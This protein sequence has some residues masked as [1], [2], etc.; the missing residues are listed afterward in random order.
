MHATERERPAQPVAGDGDEPRRWLHDRALRSSIR[1]ADLWRGCL[2][3]AAL[4]A[5]VGAGECHGGDKVLYA[6]EPITWLCLRDVPPG[7]FPGTRLTS[8]REVRCV[9]PAVAT[10]RHNMPR[11]DFASGARQAWDFRFPP[12]RST[13]ARRPGGG[14]LDGG[15]HPREFAVL[16]RVSGRMTWPRSSAWTEKGARSKTF[17]A[18]LRKICRSICDAAAAANPA[19]TRSR[20]RQ[21]QP[22]VP[23]R[24]VRQ[25]PSRSAHERDLNPP[26]RP[27]L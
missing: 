22:A 20:R 17:P 8:R 23:L 14:I 27:S 25:H 15:R 9:T 10:L 7:H 16:N 2:G 13:R 3:P 21:P 1:L 26:H 5:D 19:M 24:S 18:I 12:G 4:F 11:L 6:N